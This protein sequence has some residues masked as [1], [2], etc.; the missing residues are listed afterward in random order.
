MK[1]HELVAI[2][3]SVKTRTYTALTELDKK[4]QKPEPYNGHAK[5]FHKKDEDGED[6]PPESKKVTIKSVDVLRQIAEQN[7]EA[8]D[9]EA[10]KDVANRSAVAD[11]VVEG[12][13][14]VKDAPVSLLLY[15]E[16]QLTDVRTMVDRMPVIDETED[17]TLDTATGLFRTEASRT[18]R[19]KKV[20]RAIVKYHATEQHPA[21]TEM[22]TEDVII[23]WWETVKMSG[24]LP[25][26][27]KTAILGRV[28]R[29]LKG[30]KQA[31]ER[32]NGIDISQVNI[33]D[34]IFGYLF[35]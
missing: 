25:G 10:T 22:I 6:F 7:T 12:M 31:R 4:A 15:L 23:G 24:A 2:E 33:G 1:L 29:L 9:T 5:K 11:L 17:W 3:K 26:P 8:F 28:D 16:K 30:V 34:A 20:Q 21:Q 32:A 13:I 35:K 14:L 18:H 27:H 19:T